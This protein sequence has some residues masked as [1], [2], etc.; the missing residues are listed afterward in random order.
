MEAYN[1]EVNWEDWVNYYKEK[2]EKIE[3]E[4]FFYKQSLKAVEFLYNYN[5]KCKSKGGA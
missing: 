2:I 3:E 1:N 5:K 4:L